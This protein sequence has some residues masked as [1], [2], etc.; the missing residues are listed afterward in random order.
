MRTQMAANCKTFE[1]ARNSIEGQ[2]K[3][4]LYDA[5][6][7]A[8]LTDINSCSQSCTTWYL[9]YFLLYFLVNS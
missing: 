5:R 4:R 9:D 8:R 2:G 7:R 3:N 1:G 6:A